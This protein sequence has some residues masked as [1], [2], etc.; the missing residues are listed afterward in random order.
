MRKGYLIFDRHLKGLN[1]PI[2]TLS[3]TD[4]LARPSIGEQDDSLHVIS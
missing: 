2:V 1:E 3:E 4:L